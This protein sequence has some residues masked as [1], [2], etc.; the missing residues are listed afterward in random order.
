MKISRTIEVEVCEACHED[1]HHESDVRECTRCKTKM[2]YQCAQVV[3][4]RATLSTPN[5]YRTSSG[6]IQHSS[7]CNENEY[8]G[9]FCK[10]CGL[11]VIE[12]LLQL[13]ITKKVPVKDTD[14]GWE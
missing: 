7:R 8:S 11:L 14:T 10:A 5:S 3:S 9:R 12:T 1:L 4:V 13:G 6:Y 2:C